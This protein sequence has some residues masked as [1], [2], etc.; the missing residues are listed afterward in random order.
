[1]GVII[2][3]WCTEKDTRVLVC[4]V[5][6]APLRSQVLWKSIKNNTANSYNCIRAH[7]LPPKR[8]RLLVAVP[9]GL[10]P[11][12][13]T[14]HCFETNPRWLVTNQANQGYMFILLCSELMK[15]QQ[16]L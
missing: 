14:T 10:I 13:A 15:Q 1:M 3:E 2:I 7:L 12:T 4:L 5:T 11:H 6:L 16:W 8:G 9:F